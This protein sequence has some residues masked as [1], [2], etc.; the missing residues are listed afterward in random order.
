MT[1][2]KTKYTAANTRR[3]KR[4]KADYLLKY[5]L[6]G[7]EVG[8]E[9]ANIKDISA[10][11]VKFWAARPMPEGSLVQLSVLLPPL[12]EELKAVGRIVRV[13]SAKNIPGEYVAV[14]FLELNLDAQKALNDFIEYTA[15]TPAARDLIDHYQLVKRAR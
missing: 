10:G 3:Y 9:L 8:P 6:C 14:N 4:L 1:L 13:R 12:D 5:Q 2:F 7:L 11:G 15:T